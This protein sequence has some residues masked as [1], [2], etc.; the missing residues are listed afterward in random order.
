MKEIKMG[1][2][3][4]TDSLEIIK[5]I[6][7]D[8][9]NNVTIYFKP[10]QTFDELYDVKKFCEENILDVLLFS[11]Q[12]PYYWV[13]EREN[14]EIPMLYIPRNGTCLYRTLFNIHLDKVD[15]NKVSFDTISEEDIKEAYKELNIPI[16]KIYTLAY[17]KYL[18]YEQI[19]D[20]HLKLINDGKVIAVATCLQKPYDILKEK[21]IRTYR[22][23]PTKSIIRETF[24]KGLLYGESTKFKE[25]QF[26]II[27]V[28]VED[29]LREIYENNNLNYKMQKIL[30]ELEKI[31]IDYSELLEG[32]MVKLREGEYAIF[33]TRGTIENI[34]DDY[35]KFPLYKDIKE[36]FPFLVTMGVGFGKTAKTARNNAYIA[37][38]Y[39]KLNNGNCFITTEYGKI[40][41][42]LIPEE[43][44]KR[45]LFS[46]D[47]LEIAKKVGISAI[48]LSRIKQALKNLNKNEISSRELSLELNI[49][50]R[51]ARRILNKLEKK[52]Y[53]KVVGTNSFLNK[54]GVK[55]RPLWVYKINL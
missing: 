52:G 29:V 3:G 35:S 51:S 8:F 44:K 40:I 20:Y 9:N 2:I 14:I 28:R 54:S 34:T 18:P 1:I 42:P 49:S 31:I 4:P 46:N 10:Y 38:N 5:S 37:L 47:L 27:V 15:F 12:A 7:E 16:T 6:V 50:E 19:I 43:S 26:A 11:G 36:N 17:N 48:N 13:K 55:G 41:G 24:I 33:A 22:I 32:T 25:T 23:F 53:A 45:E 39:S 21:G 30:L